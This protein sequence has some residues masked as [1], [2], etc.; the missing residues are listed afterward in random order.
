MPGLSCTAPS[1]NIKTVHTVQPR[2]PPCPCR[3]QVTSR[4]SQ[5]A[6]GA[7][8]PTG[9]G[10]GMASAVSNDVVSLQA[11]VEHLRSEVRKPNT[12]HAAQQLHAARPRRALLN[13]PHAQVLRLQKK[14]GE[15]HVSDVGALRRAHATL[16]QHV[17]A[18]YIE[19]QVIR[20]AC[21]NCA[22][23]LCRSCI[24]MSESCTLCDRFRRRALA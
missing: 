23:E 9:A 4:H 3:T 21:A 20:P 13:A 22:A 14:Q 6:S 24:L 8:R 15:L 17:Q 5:R 1:K 18:L 19:A 12:L 7:L 16:S 11:Q 2:E 10:P